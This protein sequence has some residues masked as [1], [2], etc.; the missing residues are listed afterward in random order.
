MTTMMTTIWRPGGL[1]E[2]DIHISYDV[3][4]CYLMASVV[5]PRAIMYFYGMRTGM[6]S[7]NAEP[8]V[9]SA[10]AS[11][12]SE[13][14]RSHTPVKMRVPNASAGLGRLLATYVLV[15]LR[16]RHVAERRLQRVLLVHPKNDLGRRWRQRQQRAIG[17]GWRQSHR[18]RQLSARP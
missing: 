1:I 5:I 8:I 7:S 6:R 9:L 18:W 13:L 3:G 12:Y 10:C 17:T 4:L 14:T 15:E 16:L 2:S 11:H